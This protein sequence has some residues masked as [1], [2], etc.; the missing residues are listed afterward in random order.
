MAAKGQ[1]GI[2]GVLVI[3]CFLIWMVN[4]GG[5]HSNNSLSRYS[6]DLSTFLN[7]HYTLIFKNFIKNKDLDNISQKP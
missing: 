4:M 5:V 1:N 6:Y 7:V 2:P 3:F